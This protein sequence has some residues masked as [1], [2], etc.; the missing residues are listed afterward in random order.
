MDANLDHQVKGGWLSVK[1][2]FQKREGVCVQTPASVPYCRAVA[3][4]IL[5]NKAPFGEDM[6]WEDLAQG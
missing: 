5:T 4:F 3:S 6:G 1:T 2:P